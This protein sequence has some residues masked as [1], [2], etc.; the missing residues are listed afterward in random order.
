[1]HQI[2]VRKSEKIIVTSL[3]AYVLSFQSHSQPQAEVLYCAV[4]LFSLV[5]PGQSYKRR[6]L[7]DMNTGSELNLKR[8]RRS[9][10]VS[11]GYTMLDNRELP[12]VLFVL[13]LLSVVVVRMILLLFQDDSRTWITTTSPE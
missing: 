3:T 5:L 7:N 1:M 8:F 10:Q 9:D 13:L 6:P 11:R 2:R 12:L 4:L